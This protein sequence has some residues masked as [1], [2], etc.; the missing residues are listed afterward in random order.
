MNWPVE[1]AVTSNDGSIRKSIREFLRSKIFSRIQRK[2]IVAFLLVVLLPL[3][4]TAFYG[5]W[6]TSRALGKQAVEV[7]LSDL[8]QRAGQI[9]GYLTGVRDDIFYLSQIDA[10]TA[11]IDARARGDPEAVAH[12]RGRLASEFYVFAQTHPM[13]Y[14]VRYIAEDGWEFVRVNADHGSVRVV[15]LD[16]LQ[17]K[18]GRYYFTETIGLPRGEIYVSPIDLNR[19]FGRVE[20]PYTPVIRYA[21]SVFYADGRRAGIVILNLYADGFLRYVREETHRDSRHALSLVDREGYYL[22]HPDPEKRWGRPGDVGT[23]HRLQADFPQYWTDILSAQAGTEIGDRNVMVH[24]P[25]FPPGQRDGAYWVLLH[26]ESKSQLFSSVRSFRFTAIGILVVALLG[27]VTMA[28]FLAWSITAP[29]LALTERVKRFGEGEV[30]LPV[31]VSSQ[32]EIGELAVAFDDMAEA[33]QA[34]LDRLSLLNQSG[35]RIAAQ[36]ECREVLAAVLQAAEE[37][38]D[39]DYWVVRLVDS[40]DTEETCIVTGGDEKW[41]SRAETVGARAIR[42]AALSS[43]QWKATLLTPDG[44]RAGV[45]CCAPLCVGVKQQGLIELYGHQPDLGD[46]ATG[47][48]LAALAVQASI[49]LENAKLYG[50]LADH[51]AQLQTLV[52][53]LITAQEEE[54]RMVAYDIH[55]GLIQRLVGAR[56]H[57]RNFVA[58]RDKASI[59]AETALD[60]G[61]TQLATAIA[62]ARRVIEG[63][64]PATLDD[65]GLVPTLEQYAQELGAEAGW[66]VTVKARPRDPRLPPTVEITAFRIAQEALTNAHK[67]AGSDRVSV[68]IDARDSWLV[69]KVRDSGQGF[70]LDRVNNG[71]RCLGLISMQE[72]ARVLGGECVIRSEPEGGTTVQAMLPLEN[73]RVEHG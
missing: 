18:A 71:S 59:D 73:G 69:V 4:G 7:A 48:L 40:D 1:S 50:T 56:L 17:H 6:V 37:L 34:N 44:G 49:A 21:T 26:N 8:R 70:E 42:Q 14:Q 25:V 15:P 63:L 28:V 51:R 19:E 57:L 61:L 20:T 3:I 67:H 52:K 29:V 46:P 65:L 13:Y 68:S 36:L 62:E 41:A 38:F 33:L 10:L 47:N 43:G 53:R 11:L 58:Q 30:D 45:M 22:A 35:Q 31:A 5:N 27:A 2:L 66:D 16:Q 32:D 24:V 9:E 54:R 55:D 23:G 72:R 64:R 39:A 12:W 60:K